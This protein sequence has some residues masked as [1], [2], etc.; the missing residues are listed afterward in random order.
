[1]RKVKNMADIEIIV[2]H[3]YPLTGTIT[4]FE[5]YMF[6]TTDKHIVKH[7][8]FNEEI[9][10]V[11]GSRSYKI[12]DMNQLTDRK[13]ALSLF[14]QLAKAQGIDIPKPSQLSCV[15]IDFACDDDCEYSD[16]DNVY[17]KVK[18][19]FIRFMTDNN[20]VGVMV[21]HFYQNERYPHVHM[22]YQRRRGQHDEFQTYFLKNRG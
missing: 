10:I 3:D 21:Q 19:E 22:L 7:T 6:I 8:D 1:M 4:N 11:D 13:S 15:V 9:V 2:G 17:D 16:F 14:N 5:A 18:N 20:R 12:I